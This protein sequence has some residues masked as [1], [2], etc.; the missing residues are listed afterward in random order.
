[1]IRASGSE[2]DSSAHSTATVT[3]ASTPRSTSTTTASITQSPASP[4]AA[5]PLPAVSDQLLREKLAAVMGSSGEERKRNKQRNKDGKGGILENVFFGL[6][7]RP[8][9]DVAAPLGLSF[10]SERAPCFFSISPPPSLSHSLPL[11]LSFSSQSQSTIQTQ[12]ISQN[13]PGGAGSQRW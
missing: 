12:F 9:G 6:L 13:W 4:L 8:R 1:M 5:V 3:G 11:T 7:S 10:S 2:Y